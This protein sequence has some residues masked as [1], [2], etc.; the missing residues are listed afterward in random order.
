MSRA[1]P[2]IS[3]APIKPPPLPQGQAGKVCRTSTLAYFNSS[4]VPK[5]KSFI[6]LKP[7]VKFIKLFYFFTDDEAK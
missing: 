5:K 1:G 7:E 3:R 6:A 2:S 4:S